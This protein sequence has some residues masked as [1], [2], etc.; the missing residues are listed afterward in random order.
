MHRSLDGVTLLGRSVTTAAVPQPTLD[1]LVLHEMRFDDSICLLAD[2][3]FEA[4][5]D[6]RY[7]EARLKRHAHAYLPFAASARFMHALKGPRR[8]RRGGDRLCRWRDIDLRRNELVN[9]DAKP[10]GN[11]MKHGFAWEGFAVKPVVYIVTGGANLP[12][13]GTLVEILLLQNAL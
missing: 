1:R 2:P 13:S 11:L 9:V 5:D 12:R 6:R 7:Q 10:L 8:R 4:T 3:L